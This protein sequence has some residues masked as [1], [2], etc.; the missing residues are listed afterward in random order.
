M[1]LI[2]CGQK[3]QKGS[4]LE[5]TALLCPDHQRRTLAAGWEGSAS[6]SLTPDANSGYM[7]SLSPELVLLGVC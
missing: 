3:P 5:K 4:E 6:G 7:S 2:G 1:I